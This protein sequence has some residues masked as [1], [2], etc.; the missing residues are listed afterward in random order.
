MTFFSFVVYDHG[1]MRRELGLGRRPQ[2]QDKGSLDRG[3]S[4]AFSCVS[5]VWPQP[6]P[7]GQEQQR[8]ERLYKKSN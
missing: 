4:H 3:H 6:R 7:D 5:S 1:R 2:Q 8:K